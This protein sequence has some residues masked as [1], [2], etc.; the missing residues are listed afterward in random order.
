MS[1]LKIGTAIEKVLKVTRID[2]VAKAI[3][4][5]SEDCGCQKRRDKL[6]SMFKPKTK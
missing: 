6:D 2:R 3:V 4:G 1:E 5:E